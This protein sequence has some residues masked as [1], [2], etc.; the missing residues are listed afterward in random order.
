MKQLI[1]YVLLALCLLL[2]SPAPAQL[3]HSFFVDKDRKIIIDDLQSIA[4]VPAWVALDPVR[5]ETMPAELKAK[6]EDAAFFL[7]NMLFSS[8]LRSNE[9]GKSKL[10]DIYTVNEKLVKQKAV[11]SQLPVQSSPAAICEMLGADAV[12]LTFVSHDKSFVKSHPD[13]APIVQAIQWN[14][15]VSRKDFVIVLFHKTG[16]PLWATA[17]YSGGIKSTIREEYQLFVGDVISLYGYSR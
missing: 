10:Q 14:N 1:A 3:R 13:V 17:F 6:E 15:P 11:I 16:K 8:L 2:A 5:Y 9:M 7:Q 4:V 12:L